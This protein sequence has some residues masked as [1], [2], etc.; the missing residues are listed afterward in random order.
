MGIRQVVLRWQTADWWAYLSR[1]SES[2][3][4]FNHTICRIPETR[5]DSIKPDRG[6]IQMCYETDILNLPDSLS[7]QVEETL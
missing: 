6:V 7:Y 5:K 1:K 4:R 3:H 2:L